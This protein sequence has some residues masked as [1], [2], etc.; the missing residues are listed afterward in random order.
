MKFLVFLLFGLV[1]F[2]FFG[3]LF[4]LPLAA[5][6]ICFRRCCCSTRIVIVMK[7]VCKNQNDSDKQNRHPQTV[8]TL[9]SSFPTP[10]PTI[11]RKGELYA[12]LAT[13]CRR[14][15]SRNHEFGK[16][17]PKATDIRLLGFQC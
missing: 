1:L 13:W 14:A 8:R 9:C 2:I 6:R 3:Q 10:L 12:T 7:T 16:E 15:K 4:S 11:K 5:G 17:D